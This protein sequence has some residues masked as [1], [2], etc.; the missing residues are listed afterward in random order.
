MYKNSKKNHLKFL[1]IFTLLTIVYLIV[2]TVLPVNGH[3]A[4]LLF[5]DEPSAIPPWA[6]RSNAV[7]DFQDEPIIVQGVNNP[8]EHIITNQVAPTQCHVE[9]QVMKRVAGRCMK[10][11]K[12]SRGCVSGN[13]IHP[14]HPQCL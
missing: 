5:E 10:L 4:E 7:T 3:L 1:N 11:G 9:F 13:Y 12:N 8:N 6:S 14:F 2:L